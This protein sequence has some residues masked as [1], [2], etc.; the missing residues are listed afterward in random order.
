MVSQAIQRVLARPHDRLA[1]GSLGDLKRAYDDELAAYGTE[2]AAHVDRVMEVS[3]QSV[4]RVTTGG[5]RQHRRCDECG[6][7]IEN[8][9]RLTR[10]YCSDRCRQR[11]HRKRQHAAP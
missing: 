11:A 3:R 10:W 8:A 6:G 4:Q 5:I 1:I 9:A 2:I 7:P